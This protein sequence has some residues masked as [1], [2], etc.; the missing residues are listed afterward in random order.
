[1]DKG[2]YLDENK[3]ESIGYLGTTREKASPACSAM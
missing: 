3:V 2:V 1:M